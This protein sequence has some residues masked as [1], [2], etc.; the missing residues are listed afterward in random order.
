VPYAPGASADGI[1]RI[2]GREL[3]STLGQPVIVD[4]KPGGGGATA[5]IAMSNS[6]AGGYTIGLGAAGAIAVQPYL[7][8]SP[9]L[10]PEKQLQPVAKVADIPLVLVA[11]ANAGFP[12][13]QTLLGKAKVQKF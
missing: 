13:L 7:P 11:G 4:N 6:R 2:L 10:D 3:S 12:T 1:A 5:L 9:P 8:D